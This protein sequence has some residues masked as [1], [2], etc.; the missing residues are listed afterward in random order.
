M[1]LPTAPQLAAYTFAQQHP[2]TARWIRPQ[3]RL[4][5]LAIEHQ[6]DVRMASD[7]EFA[8]MRRDRFA[9]DL[10]S[11]DLLN[12]W[13]TIVDDLGVMLSMRWEGGDPA[14]PFVDACALSR[15]VKID[16]GVRA[17]QSAAWHRFGRFKPQYLRWWS[18]EPAGH[19]PGTLQDKRFLA[20]P[21][22]ELV[23]TDVPASLRLTGAEDVDHYDTAREAYA[24]VDREHPAHPDQATLEPKADLEQLCWAGTL[25][26]VILDGDW[27]GYFGVERG[28]KL[29]LDGYKIVELILT[30]RARGRGLGRYLSCL[31]ATELAARGVPGEAVIIG[32]WVRLPFIPPS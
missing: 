17:L 27:C 32:G 12:T 10:P 4:R 19:Y 24:M 20:A 26:D 30:E 23:G 8:A 28:H 7:L 2:A 18:R 22:H 6:L 21:V 9:P 1:N 15:P 16:E 3:E 31:L 5:L 13:E 11:E 25:F 29:G 14:R